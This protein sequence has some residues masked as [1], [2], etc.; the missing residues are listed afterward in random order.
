MIIPLFLTITFLKKKSIH[1][2]WL[3]WFFHH[4]HHHQLKLKEQKI[5]QTKQSQKR[6]L[7]NQTNYMSNQ[8]RPNQ[9][10]ELEIFRNIGDGCCGGYGCCGRD[11]R[12][13]DGDESPRR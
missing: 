13:Y 1:I 2:Q 4:Y 6:N 11:H 10:I 3:S 8:T 5:K 7:S 12:D 9:Q